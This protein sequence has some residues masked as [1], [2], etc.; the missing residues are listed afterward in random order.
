MLASSPLHTFHLNNLEHFQANEWLFNESVTTRMDAPI[1]PQRI[2]LTLSLA[3]QFSFMP[4]F[5]QNDQVKFQRLGLEHGLSQSTIFCILQDRRG[6]MW[7][8][9][10]DGLNRFDGYTFTVYRH[11]PRNAN[12][13]SSSSVS[14]LIEDF[15][16]MLWVGTDRGLNRFDPRT[17]NFTRFSPEPADSQS[18]ISN[19][20]TALLQDHQ[21]MLWVGT[22]EGLNWFDQTTGK[23]TRFLLGTQSENV[24]NAGWIY[25]LYEDHLKNLWVAATSGL[26]M[27]DTSR[28]NL[29]RLTH[30]TASEYTCIT[31]IIQD[32]SLKFWFGTNKGQVVHAPDEPNWSDFSQNAPT[33]Q[34]LNFSSVISSLLED[35]NGTLWFGPSNGLIAYDRT[36][37]RSTR[38]VHDPQDPVSLSNNIITS[39]WQDRSGMLWVGTLSG[40]NKLTLPPILFQHL[41]HTS[42]ELSNNFVL[43]FLEDQSGVLW[44]GTAEGLNRFDRQSDRF[45][46]VVHDP[47]YPQN[48]YKNT[49]NALYE[50][51]AQELWVGTMSGLYRRTSAANF[52]P[53]TYFGQGARATSGNIINFIQEDHHKALWVGTN[54][55]L[56]R[57]DSTRS[58]VT[59]FLPNPNDRFSL[60]STSVASFLETRDSTIWIGTA[61]GLH[62]LNRNNSQFTRF[63]Y[64]PND[65]SSI[66]SDFIFTMHEDRH[67]G[68]WLATDNGLNKLDRET[69]R[70]VCY[71]T[72]DGL[73]S[74]LVVG[75]LED[76]HENL[77]VSTAHGLS[78]FNY[79]T[80]SF[81]NYD[82][83]DGLQSNEFNGAY[84]KN[85][86]GE[87]FLGGINGFNVFHP[88]SIKDNPYIPPVF[89]TRFTSFNADEAEGRAVV[90]A[91]I[92]AKPEIELSYKDNILT[93]EFAAL[94]YRASTKNQYAYKLEGFNDNWIHL[95]TKREATFT[96]LDPG[97][98]TL[99]VKGSNNDGVWNEAGASLKIIITPPWW[100]TWWAYAFYTLLLL[101]AVYVLRRYEL[102]RMRLKSQLEL[103]HVEAEKMKELDH[104]KSRFF[105]NISHEFRTPLTLI[106]GPVEQMRSNDFKGNVHEAY[107]MI[108]R[109][110]RRLLR[111]I[112]QLLDLARL[113]AG[114]LVLHTQ[115]ANIVAFIKGLV[116]SFASAAESKGID[117][118]FTSAEEN[119]FAH[120]D[121]DKLEK[122]VS[123]LLSNALK[124]TPEGGKISVQLSVNSDQLSVNSDQSS[125]NSD[126]SSV[127]SEQSSV[128]SE[129]SRRKPLITDNWSLNTGNCLLITVSRPEKS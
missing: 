90:D 102:N 105:A 124:F 113:E 80:L 27:I 70:F 63:T 45:T 114:S 33:A 12:S 108:L 74:N 56:D 76:D 31:S 10:Q 62:C 46:R 5:A 17:Q 9:T 99:R 22:G 37:Q 28:K 106:L 8:G 95:G 42:S 69:G 121:H 36:A 68:I 52:E 47:R 30:Y 15:E 21:G 71:T 127:A 109:N 57:F 2:L 49:I 82:V 81:R 122:I 58:H 112:N 4:L 64:N 97:E 77:W 61:G 39:L 100:K 117:L 1:K 119:L 123:N 72:Q 32:R 3:L 60:N 48:I 96:N 79:R 120:F 67:G 128:A 125:V 54:G 55:G 86:K 53:Y 24:A 91:N 98:Y 29:S 25:E 129:Q 6:F 116:F 89:I 118:R 16:N 65:P 126:Q 84:F 35:R 83:E 101:G 85:S 20:I 44:V 103:E 51:S 11:E 78:R 18:K 93:F 26:Y 50:D 104:L 66:S 73:A 111:L 38:L 43:S 41:S 115:P 13:L 23:F 107:D 92:S 59:R 19:A 7:F 88:D 110:G 34:T 40:L 14:A 87:M 75:I 94:S